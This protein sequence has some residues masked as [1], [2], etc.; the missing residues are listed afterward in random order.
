MTDGVRALIR[1]GML[2]ETAGTSARDR[3][4]ADSY[5]DKPVT[6]FEKGDEGPLSYAGAKGGLKQEKEKIGLLNSSQKF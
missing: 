2:Q 1:P 4:D 5:E 6:T 3:R